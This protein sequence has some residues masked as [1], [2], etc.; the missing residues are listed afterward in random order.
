MQRRFNDVVYDVY[1][2]VEDVAMLNDSVNCLFA[3]CKLFVWDV[4]KMFTRWLILLRC[5]QSEK[6]DCK[7]IDVVEVVC[8]VPESFYVL[9]S[10]YFADVYHLQR[11]LMML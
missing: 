9:I 4:I 6:V 5:L 1:N 10:F 3:V 7:M 11:R 8:N 2:I